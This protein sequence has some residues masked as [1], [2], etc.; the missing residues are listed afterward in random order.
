MSDYQVL[1]P[2]LTLSGK[3]IFAGDELSFDKCLPR[4]SFLRTNLG[5]TAV[6]IVDVMDL[7]LHS[8]C[9]R[10]STPQILTAPSPPPPPNQ[11]QT[12]APFNLFGVTSGSYCPQGQMTQQAAPTEGR[13][14]NLT[15]VMKHCNPICECGS[16]KVNSPVHSNWC[17]KHDV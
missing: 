5:G 1:T 7:E 9:F 2:F 12:A 3:Q 14:V 4:G 10:V 13:N 16:D 15:E 11:M 6:D 8:F 17:P